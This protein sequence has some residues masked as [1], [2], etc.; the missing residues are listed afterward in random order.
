MSTTPS[1]YAS[2][3]YVFSLSAASA[4]VAYL[5]MRFRFLSIFGVTLGLALLHLVHAATFSPFL[6][7]AYPL[8]VRNPYLSGS[9]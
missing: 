2:Q 4:S 7:P 9:F 3:A 5:N 8:A 1:L 6:P